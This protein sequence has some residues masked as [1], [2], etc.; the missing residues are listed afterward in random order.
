MKTLPQEEATPLTSVLAS[1][2]ACSWLGK[3]AAPPNLTSI[4][5]ADS[6]STSFLLRMEALEAEEVGDNG[7]P[8]AS[9][10]T[11]G[12]P[13]LGSGALSLEGQV[14]YGGGSTWWVVYQ[15]TPHGSG[16]ESCDGGR[17]T[18]GQVTDN[19]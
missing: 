14:P 19:S 15:A 12:M 8:G 7:E 16:Q 4:T 2:R 6:P 5:R 17:G 13:T 18:H 10:E 11:W 1:S 3:T 9:W